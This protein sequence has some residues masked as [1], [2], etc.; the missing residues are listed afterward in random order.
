MGM[1]RV[2]NAK[3]ALELLKKPV[4]EGK[5]TIKVNDNFA[6]WNNNTYAVEYGGGKCAVNITEQSADIET[7]QLAL[8]LMILG[9]Y[10]FE[11]IAE[12]DDVQVNDN[13]QTLKQVFYKKNL[14]LT[15]YF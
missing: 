2:V 9:A 8:V 5:F 7:S 10:Q 3:R 12:R 15:D 14:L 6:G 13:M 4:G 1:S 11:R